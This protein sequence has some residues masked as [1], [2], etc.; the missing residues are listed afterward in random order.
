MSAELCSCDPMARALAVAVCF[1]AAE[2]LL[3]FDL[4]TVVS[5]RCSCCRTRM[6][7]FSSSAVF[8][9]LKQ[10]RWINK[11]NVFKNLCSLVT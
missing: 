3:Y 6:A 10:G 1:A 5:R 8:A 11:I 2:R 4:A 7:D 9:G